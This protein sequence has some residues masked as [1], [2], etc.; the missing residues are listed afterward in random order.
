VVC[1]TCVVE[2]TGRGVV[3]KSTLSSAAKDKPRIL[4]SGGPR[5]II[6]SVGEDKRKIEYSCRKCKYK[7]YYNRETN[8][9][10]KCP[11]CKSPVHMDV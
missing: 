4:S 10:S 6:G 7:F 8:Y 3:S 2:R 5:R 9:P 11:Y 1:S